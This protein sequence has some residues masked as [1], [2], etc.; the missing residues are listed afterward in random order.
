MGASRSKKITLECIP[1]LAGKCII[2]TGGNTG[3][4]LA[5]AKAMLSKAPEKLIITGRS[6]E[7]LDGALN[8]LKKEFPNIKILSMIA[9]LSSFKSIKKFGDELQTCTDKVDILVN[10][11]G[12]F[13]PPFTRTSEGLEV[14][15]GTNGVGTA[16]LTSVVLPLI[17]KSPAPRI[18][19]VSSGLVNGISEAK[20]N[21][22]MKDIGGETLTET[23]LNAYSFSKILN[24]MYAYELQRRLID[25]NVIVTSCEPGFVN[26]DIQ[27]KTN[28]ELLITKITGTL[29]SFAAKSTTEGAIPLLYCATSPDI[30]ADKSLHGK[31]FGEGPYVKTFK[32]PSFITPESCARAYDLL[33]ELIQRKIQS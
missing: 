29:S 6:Q 23:N 32:V 1:E 28:K 13:V 24:T 11:A 27:K 3:I 26:S 5:T 14:T 33:E 20:F 2:V 15:I 18:V 21:D 16:Y 19:I 9:D 7:K 4:G 10:N 17:M 30:A 12:V 25:S 22:F 31:M 8:S